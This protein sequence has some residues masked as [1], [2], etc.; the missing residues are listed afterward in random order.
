[1]GICCGLSWC[2]RQNQQQ[3]KPASR[4][5]ILTEMG[6]TQGAG[7][8]LK[9]G[10]GAAHFPERARALLSLLAVNSASGA[11]ILAESVSAELWAA[12]SAFCEI[13]NRP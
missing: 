2:D 3:I 11:V 12:G 7:D 6:G 5:R 8:G 13:G 9:T 10:M 4:T 1:M